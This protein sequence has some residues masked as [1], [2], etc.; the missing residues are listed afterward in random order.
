MSGAVLNSRFFTRLLTSGKE[1]FQ[2]VYVLKEYT[3]S[4][5]YELTMLISITFSVTFLALA[6]LITKLC[7]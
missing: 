5:T 2:H 7:Q 1:D 3:I 4:T 6:S